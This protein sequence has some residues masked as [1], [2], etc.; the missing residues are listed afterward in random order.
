MSSCACATWG[1]VRCSHTAHPLSDVPVVCT[2]SSG[3]RGAQPLVRGSHQLRKEV[4]RPGCQASVL[5]GHNVQAQML[6]FPGRF[7]LRKCGFPGCPPPQPPLRR[8]QPPGHPIPS[9]GRARSSG[10]TPADR[11]PPGSQRLPAPLAP[12]VPCPSPAVLPRLGG[13]CL[14]VPLAV[15]GAS[16]VRLSVP[17]RPRST[18]RPWGRAGLRLPGRCP[19]QAC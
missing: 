5:R 6:S 13:G 7:L 17:S 18:L 19:R 10:Q 2:A 4:P 1:V 16:H 14:P 15:L 12:A 11:L 9:R 8:W 3:A